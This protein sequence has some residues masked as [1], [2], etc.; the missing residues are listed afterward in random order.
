[1]VRKWLVSVCLLLCIMV[2]GCGNQENKSNEEA[3]FLHIEDDANRQVILMKKP[4]RIISLSP[5]FLEPLEAVGAN[6][7]ARP[8]SKTSVPEFAKNLEEVG[9]VYNINVEKVV[10]LKPDL[11]IAYQGMH[12][13]LVPILESN[14]I[15]VI[16]LKMKTYQEVKDKIKLFGQIT[17]QESKSELVMAKMDDKIQKILKKMPK[18]NKRI[19]ILHSTAKSVT[20]ELDGS[21]AGSTAK[22]LG[23]T[24]IALA[25]KNVD[26]FSESIPYSMESLVEQDPKIIFVVTM[27]TMEEIKKRM[28]ADVESNPAWASLTAVQNKHVYFLPQ[29]LFLLNPGLNYPEAF[30][31]MAR[32]A[33]PE[34]FEDGK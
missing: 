18:E 30:E 27:G 2:L 20:V 34:V 29:E 26:Q 17:G 6:L 3:A 24:N 8:T 9:A 19:A 14:H 7:I 1:M 25:S 12:D 28:L 5:S 31:F 13:K 10:A 16:I 22:T 15:P 4:E 32:L 11:V 23:L 33:Y 21:I